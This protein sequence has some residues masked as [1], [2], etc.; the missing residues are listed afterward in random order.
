MAIDVKAIVM[1]EGGEK[2]K[3]E[4][5]SCAGLRQREEGHS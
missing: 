1:K 5:A 3:E 4:R 2:G